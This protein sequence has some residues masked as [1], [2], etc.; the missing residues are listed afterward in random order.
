MASSIL[1]ATKLNPQL[2]VA[3]VAYGDEA[4]LAK[5]GQ[6]SGWGFTKGSRRG[7][8]EIMAEIL[9]YCGQQKTKTDIMYK[10]NLNY[11]QLKKHLKALTSRG[12][13]LTY[14]NKYVTTH[15]GYRFLRLFV[16]LNNILSS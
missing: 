15:K 9:C 3:A 14:K 4:K 5:L 12:L 7:R 8:L 6:N 10:T 13:L 1:R 11:A 16:Q 2:P